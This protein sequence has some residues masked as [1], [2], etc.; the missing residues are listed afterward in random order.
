MSGGV[1]FSG[2]QRGRFPTLLAD[3]GVLTGN[4]SWVLR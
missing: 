3:A 4:T 2:T 1:L